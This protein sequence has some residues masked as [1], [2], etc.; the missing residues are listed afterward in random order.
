[1]ALDEA[2]DEQRKRDPGK[3]KQRKIQ[4][5]VDAMPGQELQHQALREPDGYGVHQVDGEARTPERR[6]P[7]LRLRRQQVHPRQHCRHRHRAHQPFG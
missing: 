1:M 7:C 3:R 2:R 5:K 6:E 4:Q